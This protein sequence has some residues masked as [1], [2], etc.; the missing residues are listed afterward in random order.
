[1]FCHRRLHGAALAVTLV[2]KPAAAIQLG[3]DI[4]ALSAM[5][6]RQLLTMAR[7]ATAIWEPYGVALDWVRPG[8]QVLGLPAGHG[9]LTISRDGPADRL[10]S[11][12]SAARRLGAVLFLKGRDVAENTVALDVEAT[13][14]TVEEARWADGR[15]AD[16]PSSLREELLGRALGRVLAHE[17]GHYLLVWRAHTPD[18]LMRAAFHGE[19]LIEPGRRA[20]ELSDRLVPRLRTRLAQLSTPGSTVAEIR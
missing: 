7:E 3:V 12:P 16:W 2:L 6:P 20:F 15:V 14:Q 10:A 9:V 11:R 8:E 1:M 19:V 13:R 18:G 5:P 17:I 4:T